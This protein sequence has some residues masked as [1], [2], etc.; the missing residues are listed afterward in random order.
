MFITQL[1]LAYLFALTNRNG[2]SNGSLN[3]KV[4]EKPQIEPIM[5]PIEDICGQNIWNNSAMG[6]V[7]SWVRVSYWSFP[8]FIFVF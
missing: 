2:I 5:L 7:A 3:S 4:V 6:S 1:V 8:F